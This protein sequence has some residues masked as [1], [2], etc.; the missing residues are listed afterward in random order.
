MGALKTYLSKKAESNS[1][2]AFD[3][4][5]HDAAAECLSLSFVDK[6]EEDEKEG[7]DEEEKKSEPKVFSKAEHASMQAERKDAEE[8]YQKLAD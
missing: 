8:M 2:F 7:S 6:E 5:L 1:P 4:K 3:A